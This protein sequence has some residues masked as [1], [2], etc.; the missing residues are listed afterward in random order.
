MDLSDIYASGPPKVKAADLPESGVTVTIEKTEIVDFD[1]GKK[2][3]LTFLGKEKTLVLNK[4][5]AGSIG[6]LHGG[7]I[8]YWPGK[9]IVI[10]PTETDFSGQRVACIR[11]KKA[12]DDNAGQ[13][14]A[15]PPANFT[16][17]LADEIPF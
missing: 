6:K 15:P 17:E 8:R 5:N 3:V 11:I 9:K 16:K 2:I 4:T 1:D 13:G 7:D 12:P 14:P 10:Y